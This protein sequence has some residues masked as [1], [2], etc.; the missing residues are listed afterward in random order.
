MTRGFLAG[1]GPGTTAIGVAGCYSVLAVSI[2]ATNLGS[3]T[4]CIETG[5]G[6]SAV[7]WVDRGNG[8]AISPISNT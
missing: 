7:A 1:S 5:G 8:G 4:F 3:R 2:R 6:F